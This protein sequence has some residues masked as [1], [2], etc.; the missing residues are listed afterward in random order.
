[1]PTSRP[2]TT[3]PV[4]FAET[5]P[6][7]ERLQPIL[8]ASVTMLPAGTRLYRAVRHLAAVIPPYVTR[9]YRFGPPDDLRDVEGQYPFHWLYAAQDLYTALWEAEFCCNDITQPG[10]FYIPDAVAEQGLIAEFTLRVDVPILNLAGTAL[11]KLGI[12]DRINA[13]HAWCQWFGVRLN[14]LLAA[15]LEPGC[16]LGFCY[17]S[18]RHKNHNALAIHSQSL[19]LWRKSTVCRVVPFAELP[20]LGLLRADP[21]YAAPLPGGFSIK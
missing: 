8:A 13:E 21:N 18:R 15:W 9:T 7:V 19:E 2:E 4:V 16:P 20:H 11:S 10:T 1:M 14:E 12:Y 3:I 5:L 17:P 6:S